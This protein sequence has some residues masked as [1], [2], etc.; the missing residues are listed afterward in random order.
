MKYVLKGGDQEFNRFK[1]KVNQI[2]PD[3]SNEWWDRIEVEIVQ[4]QT[5]KPVAFH[6]DK[7]VSGWTDPLDHRPVS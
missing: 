5:E 1:E 7:V 3:L 6:V 4:V 2:I